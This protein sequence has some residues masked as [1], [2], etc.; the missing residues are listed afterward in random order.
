MQA[1]PSQDKNALIEREIKVGVNETMFNLI[2]IKPILTHQASPPPA[3]DRTGATGIIQINETKYQGNLCVNFPQAS[4]Y[5]I[6]GK[7]FRKEYTEMDAS[8]KEGAGELT[9]IIYGVLKTRLNQKGFDFPHAIPKITM[10]TFN[11][12][13]GTSNLS[14]SM[15][16]TVE[17]HPFEVILNLNLK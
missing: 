10:G 6:L 2:G 12:E 3:I 15:S 17:N 16:F 13:S 14:C 4:I 7:L 1:I 8:V 5:F 11:N 9:N